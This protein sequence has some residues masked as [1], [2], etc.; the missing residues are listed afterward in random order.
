MTA[1]RTHLECAQSC[2]QGPGSAVCLLSMLGAVDIHIPITS[3]NFGT[4][5]HPIMAQ[6][7]YKRVMMHSKRTYLQGVA[8]GLSSCSTCVHSL[9]PAAMSACWDCWIGRTWCLQH[10]ACSMV[11]AACISWSAAHHTI[12]AFNP[13][14]NRSERR[15][16]TTPKCLQVA[17]ASCDAPA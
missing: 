14:P 8:A 12:N 11:P 7:M 4:A 13:A 10:G 5:I 9:C 1:Q 6:Q 16:I 3:S 15:V 2:M 17:A